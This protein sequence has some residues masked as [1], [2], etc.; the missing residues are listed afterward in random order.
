MDETG[1][2]NYCYAFIKI[3]YETDIFI[4]GKYVMNNYYTIFDIDNNQLKVY[5]TNKGN[6]NFDQRNVIIFLFVLCVGGL[7]I[8]CYY[9]IYRN[10]YTRNIEEDNVN[11]DLM[12]RISRKFS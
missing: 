9:C 3:N 10:Y 4:A 8:L 5:K 12:E 11:E 1:A 2:G 6:I 7:L